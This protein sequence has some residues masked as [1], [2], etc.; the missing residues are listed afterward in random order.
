M[1]SEEKS[2]LNHSRRLCE[3]FLLPRRL[4][5][6][7]WKGWTWR[8]RQKQDAVN[9]PQFLPGL[10]SSPWSCPCDLPTLWDWT[11]SIPS[12]ESAGH[13]RPWSWEGVF[14]SPQLTELPHWVSH[15]YTWWLW[16]L[17]TLG[18]VLPRNANNILG[19]YYARLA[20]FIKGSLQHSFLMKLGHLETFHMPRENWVKNWGR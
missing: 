1:P 12:V 7:P 15:V 13:T 11:I 4:A 18:N 19:G 10:F 9:G 3:A 16:L 20:L 2:W 14:Y 5:S 17:S 8:T 6:G